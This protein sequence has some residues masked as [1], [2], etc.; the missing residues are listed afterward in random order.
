[1]VKLGRWTTAALGSAVAGVAA[2]AVI[3]TTATSASASSGSAAAGGMPGLATRGT[4]V[5][6]MDL[7]FK[8]EMY[9]SHGHPAG[10]DVDLLRKLAAY[11][12]VKLK[13]DNLAFTGLIPGLQT[14]KFDMVSVGLSPT[15]ARA[16]VISFSHA[17]VPYAQIVG[18]PAKDAKTITKVS[19]LNTPH[20]TI[21]ALLGST[22][23]SEAKA[24]FPKAKVEALADENSDF[25]L[26]ATGRANAIVVEDYL[27]AQYSKANPGQ[28]VQARIKPLDVQYGSYGVHKGNVALVRYLNRFLCTEDR[29]GTLARLYKKDFGVKAFPGVPACK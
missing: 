28:L 1:M 14:N 15:P 11:A 10:Y 26:V 13:I 27:L 19:Q 5:V 2:A 4:L 12:H 24:V 9:L 22:D 7:Q 23:Q 29:N 3:A 6:G 16:K 18:I 25:S 20:D 21:T 8:P 17:Y